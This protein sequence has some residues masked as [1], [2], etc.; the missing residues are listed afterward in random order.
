MP[1]GAF[2]YP[3]SLQ[4]CLPTLYRHQRDNETIYDSRILLSCL[5]KGMHGTHIEMNMPFFHG[6]N[7]SRKK[8]YSGT[9]EMARKF[10]EMEKRKKG[11]LECYL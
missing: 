9:C 10:N 5:A 8:E 4:L 6:D 2:S 7:S 1:L 3:L 11:S